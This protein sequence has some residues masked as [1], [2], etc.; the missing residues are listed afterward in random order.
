MRF[1]VAVLGC[2]MACGCAAGQSHVADFQPAVVQQA[3]AP[4]VA[5]ACDPPMIAG[6][7]PLYLDRESREPSAFAGYE[8]TTVT[9]SDVQV[10]DQHVTDH[11][12]YY[13]DAFSER[14]GVS[15]R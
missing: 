15:S 11:G 8:Q 4:A 3:D 1:S 9:Y 6:Q 14:T 10:L 13:R 5:L 2:L 12:N 7:P